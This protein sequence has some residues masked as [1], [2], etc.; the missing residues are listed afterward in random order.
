[1][2]RTEAD[3]NANGLYT[4]GDAGLG[5]PATVFSSAAANSFQEEIVKV[6][7]ESGQTLQSRDTDTFDQLFQAITTL[8]ATGGSVQP[9]VQ[10]LANNQV[11]QDVQNAGVNI[12]FDSAVLRSAS[13]EYTI[14]RSVD[15]NALVEQGTIRVA[16]EPV[17]GQ[18]KIETTSAFDD[19][20]VQ[21][22][23]NTG[24]TTSKNRLTYTTSNLTG[25]TY[26]GE[27]TLTNYKETRV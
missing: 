22:K 23:L 24:S 5:V 15:G 10:Q 21:F 25:T 20:G 11:D 17:N 13:Y 14:R 19:T 1:M 16:Y 4:E 18:W 3:G 26:V 2:H 7:L 6:V 27:L 12:E 9:V 8:I